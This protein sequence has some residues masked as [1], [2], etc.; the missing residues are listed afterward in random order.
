MLSP[1]E[2]HKLA[3]KTRKAVT[4]ED[5]KAAC[6]SDLVDANEAQRLQDDLVQISPRSASA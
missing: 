4:A 2:I 1:G 5:D 6:H 3:T